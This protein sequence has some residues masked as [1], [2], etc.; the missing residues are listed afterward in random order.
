M[1]GLLHAVVEEREPR[2][3]AERVPRRVL[4]GV[5]ARQDESRPEGGVEPRDSAVAIAADDADDRVEVELRADARRRLEDLPNAGRQP[6]D[7]ARDE[8]AD[9]LADTAAVDGRDVPRPGPRSVDA[10]QIV[11]HEVV[12]ELAHE[13]RVAERLVMGEPGEVLH[14]VGLLVHRHGDPVGHV[15]HAERLEHEAHRFAA[16]ALHEV[17]RVVAGTDLV[18]PPRHDHEQRRRRDLCDQRVEK[19][20][21]GQVRPLQ[22]VDEQHE[23]VVDARHDANQRADACFEPSLRFGRRHL[24]GR[25]LLADDQLE[26]GNQLGQGSGGR[27]HLLGESC[28]QRVELD[29]REREHLT[30]E[31]PGRLD[32]R[33]VREVAPVEIELP[34]GEPAVGG[35]HG[36]LELVDEPRLADARVPRHERE[37]PTSRCRARQRIAERGELLVT[38]EQHVGEPQSRFD[39][40]VPER[41][42]RC[43]A[44]GDVVGDRPQVVSDRGRR[45]VAVLGM[46]AQQPVDEV[47]EQGRAARPARFEA[48]WPAGDVRVDQGPR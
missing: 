30:D 12:E 3:D 29:G 15:L 43:P 44:S 10:E 23:R 24:A 19:A 1:S 42:R 40:V 38:P 45:R 5:V 36:P 21:R 32:E 48:R 13:E 31:L 9:V 33:R 26:V 28:R 18:V 35:G 11:G 20:Q 25:N 2:V 6:R 46:L 47:R 14:D 4:I 17:P 39:V 22:V 16:M 37:L 34:G 27:P 8:D 41:E 7:L